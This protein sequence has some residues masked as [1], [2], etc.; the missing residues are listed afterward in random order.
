MDERPTPDP[1]CD[2]NLA[3][4]GPVESSAA[5]PPASPPACSGGGVTC[6]GKSTSSSDPC[7]AHIKKCYINCVGHKRQLEI[8]GNK[9]ATKNVF[10]M[11]QES[12][13]EFTDPENLNLDASYNIHALHQALVAV[14][15]DTCPKGNPHCPDWRMRSSEGPVEA[16]DGLVSQRSFPLKELRKY[17]DV[18]VIDYDIIYD[19]INALIAPKTVAPNRYVLQ[20]KTCSHDFMDTAV[21]IEVFPLIA[22][23]VKIKFGLEAEKT[24]TGSRGFSLE[25]T[26]SIIIG[27][28]QEKYKFKHKFGE[29]SGKGHE[30]AGV[31]GKI[32]PDLARVYGIVGAFKRVLDLLQGHP[33]GVAWE[34]SDG[35]GFVIPRREWVTVAL[36]PPAIELA[37][38]GH[39][40]EMT[41]GKVSPFVDFE[42]EAS[43]L[44]GV[45]CKFD[46]LMCVAG[47]ASKLGPIAPIGEAMRRFLEGLTAAN[48][49]F[50]YLGV[51][52]NLDL[53][54]DLELSADAEFKDAAILTREKWAPKYET[55]VVPLSIKPNLS[56]GGG[57]TAGEYKVKASGNL[58]GK[59]TGSP[60]ELKWVLQKVSGTAAIKSGYSWT[61]VYLHGAVV[62]GYGSH[63]ITHDF[64]SMQILQSSEGTLPQL[65]NSFAA[66]IFE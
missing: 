25:V 39:H 9:L 36:T 42:F 23:Q 56:L 48:Y 30:K 40:K 13:V 18:G 11:I 20:V 45:T 29:K 51:N 55:Q 54:M 2:P 61:G 22:T 63:T 26:G 31:L 43:P 41:D 62:V 16:S 5:S 27:N 28:R 59:S 38:K 21:V 7:K 34:N 8:S 53:H 35:K 60:A 4:C 17:H 44:I 64:K 14:E 37:L 12:S 66:L 52:I 33:G 32:L 49:V 65:Y 57:I 1:V 15:A 47:V 46:L 6:V 24:A 58:G 3:S 10:Q 19:C 50:K